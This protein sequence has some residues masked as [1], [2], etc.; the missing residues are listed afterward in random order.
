MAS[1]KDYARTA[2]DV[3]FNKNVSLRNAIDAAKE[4]KGGGI[5]G[6]KSA[7]IKINWGGNKKLQYENPVVFGDKTSKN[8]DRE[9]KKDGGSKYINWGNNGSSFSSYSSSKSSKSSSSSKSSKSSAG[10]QYEKERERAERAERKRINNAKNQINL[11]W[12][13]ANSIYDETG[14]NL[15]DSEGKIS[16]LGQVRDKYATALENFKKRS[17]NAIAGNKEMIGRNQKNALDDLAN[18]VR[19][20]ISNVNLMLGTRGASGGSASRAAARAITKAAGENRAS[21]LTQYGDQM[22]GQN[23]EA[24]KVKERYELGRKQAYDWETKA[25]EEAISEFNRAKE[26]MTRLGENR[27]DWRQ[28]DLDALNDQNLQ[29]LLATLNDINT[30]ARN[31]RDNLAAKYNEY[32]TRANEV[33][34]ESINITPPSE[35][36]TPLFDENINFNNK[37]EETEDWYNPSHK[38]RRITKYD[39]YGNPIYDNEELSY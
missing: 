16:A 7:N 24:M 32:D 14:R 19:D 33:E 27:G 28:A 12:D 11:G 8:E 1:L 5:R 17:D 18:S 3:V 10:K 36:D 15:A 6:G 30:K 20:N 4:N 21:T 34:G 22:S 39:I 35:L 25:R 29:T 31:F 38:G 2:K 23:Q 37:E 13:N 9:N 26:A